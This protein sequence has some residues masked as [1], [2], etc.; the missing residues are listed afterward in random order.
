M[1]VII[2]DAQMYILSDLSAV[3]LN[4]FPRDSITLIITRYWRAS[5]FSQ[6]LSAA[7]TDFRA[8]HPPMNLPFPVLVI[9]PS[10]RPPDYKPVLENSKIRLLS[11][12][13]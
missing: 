9:L 2:T 11:T 13:A 8:V 4:S 10:I 1:L 3:R 7:Q 12:V 6:I 5:I